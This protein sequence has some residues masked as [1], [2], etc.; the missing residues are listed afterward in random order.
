MEYC[1]DI[2][3]CTFSEVLPYG[4]CCT[5]WWHGVLNRTGNQCEV[6]QCR[7]WLVLG[8][9]TIVETRLCANSAYN[10]LRS[11]M[12][13]DASLE[14]VS[15]CCIAMIVCCRTKTCLNIWDHSSHIYKHFTFMFMQHFNVELCKGALLY[16]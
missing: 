6:T 9:V 8:R 1:H 15:H 12:S 16:A 3:P 2:L 7:V 14:V 11:V 4:V 5:A 13:I 10:S